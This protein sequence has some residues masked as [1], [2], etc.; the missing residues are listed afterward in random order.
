MSQEK[1][2]TLPTDTPPT[3]CQSEVD[4]MDSIV[5]QWRKQRPDIDPTPMAVCGQIWRTSDILRQ[6]VVANW[7]NYDMDLA[8]SDVILT[9][10]RQG[11]GATLS[12]SELASDMM[13]STSAMTN[14]LDRLEKRGL[15]RRAMDPNDRRGLRI[16]LS[17]EGFALADEMVVTHVA[18]EEQMLS[19]L[20]K[21]ERDQIRFLLGK[22]E[23]NIT[24]EG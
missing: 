18:T 2:E 6:G 3:D 22:I 17:N 23:Q 4:A 15:I 21:P 8:G 16:E 13:L 1:T 7:S 12:P 10:R 11:H 20:T 24:L 9:L 19:V 14:R 5:M